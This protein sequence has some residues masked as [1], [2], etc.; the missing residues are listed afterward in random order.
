MSLV[1]WKPLKE[2]DNLRHQ[3]NRLFDEWMHGDSELNILSKEFKATWG[4][5]I[6]LKETETDIIVKAEIPGVEAKDLDIQVSQDVVY[7]AG[8]H[9]EEKRSEEKGYFRSELHYGQF[10]RTIPLPVPIKNDL[11]KSEFKNGVLTLT[12]PKIESASR[13][14][15]KVDLT[16][17]QK[18]REVMTEERQRE[19]RLKETM[20]ARA[21]EELQTPSSNGIKEEAR[22]AAV[23]QRQ[24]REHLAETMHARAAAEVG[25]SS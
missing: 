1:R 9:K 23:E 22:E 18:A 13:N 8:E 2:L 14:V 6:E 4:P 10:Q 3:M 11:V 15:V 12:L 20:R 21:T 5:A 25:T 24:D 7:L 16:T 19:E 17:Q